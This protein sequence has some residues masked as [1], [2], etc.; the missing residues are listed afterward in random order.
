MFLEKRFHYLAIAP[1]IIL[2][3]MV[4]RLF[5]LQIIKGD[6]YLQ[7]SESNFI[8]ERPIPHNRGLIMDQARVVLV[9]NRPAHDL[10]VT[11]ALLPDTQRTL[12]R[13]G[14]LLGVKSE[15]IKR[16]SQQLMPAVDKSDVN[17][18]LF[19]AISDSLKCAK[20]GEYV[21]TDQITGV[22][23]AMQK[24]ESCK[25]SITPSHFPSQ[26]AA[27][28][29]L[30]NLIGVDAEE[31]DLL[32]A[33]ADKKAKGLGQFKPVLFMSDIPFEAYAR[34]S[35]SI[36]LGALSGVAIFDS[37]K[38][39]YIHEKFASHA[40]GYLNEISANE[41]KQREG[42]YN[43]GDRVGRKGLELVY[44]SVLRGQDGV[45]RFVVDAKGRRYPA[46]WEDQLLGDSRV[47]AQTSG[48]SLLL[49]IDWELQTA[50]EKAFTGQAGSVVA[51]EVGT[52]FVLAL[53]SFP[54]YDPN[55]IVAR[56]NK[57]MLQAMAKD[58]LKPWINKALQEH[59]APGST[60]KAVT[61]VAGMEHKLIT[62]G[63]SL[64][65]TGTFYLGNA[66]W[67]CFK[68]EGHGHVDMV[69]ALKTSCDSYFYQVG[70]QL[71]PD[72]LAATARLLGFGRRTGIDLDTEIPGIIPDKSYYTKRL[73]YYAPGFVVNSSIGQGDVTVTPMQLAVA[74]DA[75]I[76]GGRIFR[77][78]L[79]RQVLDANGQLV[80][81]HQPIQEAHLTENL[82]DLAAVREGLAHVMKPGGTAYGVQFRSGMPELSKWMQ[83]SGVV[84]GGKTGTAQVVKLSKLIKHLKPEEVTYLERDHAWFVGFAPAEKPEIVVVA[85]TEHGGFGGTTS[86]PVVA[87]AIRVYYERMRGRG[88]YSA[89]GA[90]GVTSVQ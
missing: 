89:M 61:A 59:Y 46:A 54:E 80:E 65:C 45:E 70:Y 88:R 17:P 86:A 39:R 48:N 81:E 42:D 10:Y 12:R 51:I 64:N 40:L 9:D 11:F 72:R 53:A 62:P 57:K 19:A 15:Q 3:F 77:P 24:D 18:I 41:I 85:M 43:Q 84:I 52:G 33:S 23:F 69:E 78:Q 37:I 5:Y 49:S 34:I 30:Q 55:L 32:V 31:M 7:R 2:L 50:I 16:F 75:L 87:E 28:A 74:Y 90:P 14:T 68:R 73:G 82:T 13:M 58:P 27:F 1:T 63:S 26:K 22:D 71:G 83:T 38:R 47:D 29:N 36:S 20:L 56:D 4:M 21:L 6:M 67:R 76:N 60:F 35:S 8:Q 66:S 25:V 44:E 79:V